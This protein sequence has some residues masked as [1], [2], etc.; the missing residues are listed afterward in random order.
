MSDDGNKWDRNQ[1]LTLIGVII[2]AATLVASVIIP[3]MRNCFGLKDGNTPVPV[4]HAPTPQSKPKAIPQ[5]I[6]TTSAK[7]ATVPKPN[8]SVIDTALESSCQHGCE[9][10]IISENEIHFSEMANTRLFVVFH[11]EYQTA[12]IT[13]TPV[14]KQASTNAVEI[15]YTEEFTSSA[16][17][18]ILHITNVIWDSREIAVLVGRKI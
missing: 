10:S 3:E 13:I 8:P 1:I 12:S 6:E 16:G 14:G 5:K 4:S 2:A 18:F 7:L 15:G 9:V 11:D 17:D